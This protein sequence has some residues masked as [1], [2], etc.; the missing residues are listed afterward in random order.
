MSGDLTYRPAPTLQLA[1]PSNDTLRLQTENSLVEL[2]GSSADLFETH[3]LPLLDGANTT[4]DVCQQVGLKNLGDLNALLAG[5]KDAGVLLQG[6]GD[7]AFLDYAQMLGLDRAGISERLADLRVAVVGDGPLA[8]AICGELTALPVGHL[9]TAEQDHELSQEALTTL[10]AEVQY[11]ISAL[12]DAF[13]AIDYRVNR[14]VH[15]TG[16]AAFFCRV[17]LTQSF[18]GP[19]VFPSET[20]CFTCWRM[21]TAANADD[22]ER[23]M[24]FEESAAARAHPITHPVARI[25]FLAQIVSGTVI[26]ELLKSA[27]ALG[28]VSVNDRVL[29]YEPFKG[30]W[31]Q[32]SLLRRPDCP[33]C[34][35]KKF[36]F[37][38]DPTLSV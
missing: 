6:G 11:V 5:L 19:L 10:A 21:R 24:T 8:H 16:T 35:K 26:T 33:D 3:I 29:E 20:A 13:P 4:A 37:Q 23:F 18:V 14:A 31:T 22:F 36:S 17:G 38:I 1:R 32:H 25:G 28:E 7:N 15:E 12:G 30:G 9:A 27:L 34:S 2:K